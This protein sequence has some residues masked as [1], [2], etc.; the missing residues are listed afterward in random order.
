MGRK[1]KLKDR[2]DVSP[3]IDPDMSMNAQGEETVEIEI[4]LPPE[5]A[6]ESK[7]FWRFVSNTYPTLGIGFRGTMYQFNNGVLETA[8]PALA[9][10]L[11]NHPWF[12]IHFH[13][14]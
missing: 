4:P 14:G 3:E 1:K 9:E 5:P 7:R 11:E 6:P 12:K 2:E 13:R 10:A 8:N